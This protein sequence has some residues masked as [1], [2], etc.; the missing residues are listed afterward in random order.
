MSKKLNINKFISFFTLLLLGVFG[1]LT[2]INGINVIV[3]IRP[4]VGPFSL[5]SFSGI[6]HGAQFSR[7]ATLSILSHSSEP[8]VVQVI[9]MKLFIILINEIALLSI[10]VGLFAIKKVAGYLDAAGAAAK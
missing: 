8:I 10:I 1:I 7:L 3:T 4:I 6:V 9:M 2:V 5:L